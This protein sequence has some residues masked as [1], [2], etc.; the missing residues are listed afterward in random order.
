MIDRAPQR[1]ARSDQGLLPDEF[2]ESA[3][4]HALGERRG[5]LR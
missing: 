3:R 5:G 4:P 2:V 1:A